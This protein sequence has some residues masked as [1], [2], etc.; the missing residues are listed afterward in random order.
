MKTRKMAMPLLLPILVFGFICLLPAAA[1]LAQEP[2]TPPSVEIR[3]DFSDDELKSFVKANEKVAAIQIE[4]EQKMIKIIEDEGLT[5]D[6]FNEL[7]QLQRDPAKTA[8]EASPEELTSFNNAAQVII[9]ENVKIEKQMSASIEEEGIDIETYKEIMLAY[10]HNP[11]IQNR[12][13]KLVN[14]DN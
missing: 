13:N 7:L 12:V 1:A 9:D 14:G 4:S 10:Q 5:V 8:E 2:A 3:E 11:K 6:R